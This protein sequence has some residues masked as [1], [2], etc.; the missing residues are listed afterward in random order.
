MFRI[1]QGSTLQIAA[2][3]SSFAFAAFAV[4]TGRR[5]E[6]GSW[7]VSE[8]SGEVMMG[9]DRMGRVEVTGGGRLLEGGVRV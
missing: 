4:G 3:A 1:I 6:V 2:S 8:P 5:L 7:G 9:S